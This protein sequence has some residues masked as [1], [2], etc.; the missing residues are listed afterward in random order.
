MSDSPYKFLDAYDRDDRHLFFGRER[1]VQILLSDIVLGRLVVL[2]AK[3]GT[4]KTSLIHAG[5]RPA[6]EDRDYETFYVRVGRG[7][8]SDLARTE[9]RAHRRIRSLR[10]GDFAT[11]LAGAA[12]KLG[13]P[14]VI[15]FD[16]FE[17]F[18]LYLMRDN[19]PLARDFISQIAAVYR[20]RASGV[21]VVFA[22]RED[23]YV[24]MDAFRD[25]IPTIFEND[26]SVRL[27][28]FDAAQAR[29]AI[30]RPAE[31]SGVVV[32]DDLV[33][34]IV[35]DLSRGSSLIEP[36]ELQIV[37]QFLWD[38]RDDGRITLAR[39][40]ALGSNERSGTVAEQI[41]NDRLAERFTIFTTRDDFDV[42]D[43][44]LAPGTM[45]T[46]RGTKYVRDVRSL[47]GDLA[48]P[49]AMSNDPEATLG[50]ILT[51]LV[52]LRLVNSF[53]RNDLVYVELTHD[54]LAADPSRLAELRARV[55][56]IWPRRVL[57]DA[58]TRFDDLSGGFKGPTDDLEDVL[59]RARSE[60][61]DQAPERERLPLT[62]DD[63]ALLLELA[64]QRSRH[65][66]DVF[67]I[68]LAHGADAWGIVARRLRG[69]DL[70]YGPNVI[71]VLAELGTPEAVA[72]ISEAT[73]RDELAIAAIRGLEQS[74]S[75]TAVAALA[76]AL[77]DDSLAVDA[78]RA[79][80]VIASGDED[81]VAAKAAT[82]ALVSY[83]TTVLADPGLRPL[84]L[85]DLG[86]I[87]A[88]EAVTALSQLA[89]E[90]A[91]APGAKSALRRLTRSRKPNVASQAE[92]ALAASAGGESPDT[93]VSE[94]M[95]G[96][97]DA[98][99]APALSRVAP[100]RT[101]ADLFLEPHLDRIVERIRGGRVVPFVG[102]GANVVG[103]PLAQDWTPGT[104]L[105]T[106]RELAHFLA[107]STRYPEPAPTD[108]LAVAQY[109][110]A[111]LGESVLYS[112]LRDVF[113]ADYAVGPVHEL[114]AEFPGL[115]RESS[116]SGIVMFTT[117]YDDA[118]E[119]ALRDRS[120]P[121]HTLVYVAHSR[122]EARWI[123]RLP[124]GTEHEVERP[125]DIEI[126]DDTV[127]VKLQGSVDR[128]DPDNDSFVVTEDDFIDFAGPDDL[129]LPSFV[130]A[131][132]TRSHF[133]FLGQSARHWT[134][135]LLLRRLPRSR[136]LY[137]SWTVA[138][139]IAPMEQRFWEQL[140]VEVLALPLEDY[141]AQLRNAIAQV[142]GTL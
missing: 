56:N 129:R 22:M 72:L 106:G 29:A 84:A 107:A 98:R 55:R 138:P 115:A 69:A 82:S 64:L 27:R 100:P 122:S 8:P 70:S 14:M 87:E 121:F 20:E 21:H 103:R 30:V 108:L 45:T 15:F 79:L 109:V 36:A 49:L 136:R 13:K 123:H 85:E 42:L 137:N 41:L 5:V 71:D 110:D 133:L 76:N 91:T 47:M 63:A 142:T 32:E 51:T 124:D 2:F 99:E 77:D 89:G 34:A 112:Y 19:E 126:R 48:E 141:V 57:T 31:V 90:A 53:I 35:D 17:E 80:T 114:L 130:E 101:K 62:A 1:E 26:S 95:L 4:G 88:E 37:C 50:R 94:P 128:S 73:G 119:R 97:G 113:D 125:W 68:A 7:D 52:K 23:F 140:D 61:S 116:N 9:L 92:T 44:L 74:G 66:G 135:K 134:Q 139:E 75:Q 78:Q 16:Q 118:L 111:T 104:V 40:R 96:P 93:R 18:F 81:F 46:D 83:L 117:N 65:A 33:E 25:E 24:E 38:S 3:T 39:Y 131:K 11:Q 43:R 59:E 67:Q 86:R 10:R 58:R 54:Y 28:W 105:P 120:E 60:W 132:L 12:S 102:G 127:V 6:L